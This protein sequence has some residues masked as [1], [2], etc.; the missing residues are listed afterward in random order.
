MTEL[1]NPTTRRPV[2]GQLTFTAPRRGKP[3]AHLADLD[4]A[5][6][7]EAVEKL[8]HKGFRHLDLDVDRRLVEVTEPDELE[9]DPRHRVAEDGTYRL[10]ETQAR[11]MRHVAFLD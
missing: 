11:A 4:D 7:K 10:S 9:A 5:G 8:G 1:P 2:P 3:P 6:R